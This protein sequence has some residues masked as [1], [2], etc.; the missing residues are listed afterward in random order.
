MKNTGSMLVLV[1]SGQS[2]DQ[3]LCFGGSFESLHGMILLIADK[4]FMV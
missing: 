2:F 3:G 4:V 1:D